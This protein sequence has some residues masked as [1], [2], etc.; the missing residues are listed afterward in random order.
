MCQKI[1]DILKRA[2]EEERLEGS[3]KGAKERR[4][5]R[6]EPSKTEA[7]QPTKRFHHI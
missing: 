2:G 4:G 3:G 1:K 6:A 7:P 5:S